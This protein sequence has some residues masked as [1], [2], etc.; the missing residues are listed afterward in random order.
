ME[1][2]TYTPIS[3]EDAMKILQTEKHK[4]I[5]AFA[6]AYLAETG[7]MPSEVEMCHQQI[8]NQPNIIENI[9]FFRKKTE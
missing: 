8:T 5:E 9:I 6:K 2:K 7:L 3:I 4:I 1:D